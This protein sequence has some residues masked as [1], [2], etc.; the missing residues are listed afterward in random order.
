MRLR[1]DMKSFRYPTRVECSG[2]YD[3]IVDG[4]LRGLVALQERGGTWGA[5]VNEIKI[6]SGRYTKRHLIAWLKA[7]LDPATLSSPVSSTQLE[8][9]V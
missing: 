9:E 1:I 8:L 7:N 4:K 6:V 5:A 2:L 3:I